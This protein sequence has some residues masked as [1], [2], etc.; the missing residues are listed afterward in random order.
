MV[1]TALQYD[2]AQDVRHV[3][4]YRVEAINEDQDG[5]VYVAIFTG[6]D[7][8][9]RASEYAAWKS[10]GGTVKLRTAN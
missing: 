5:E 3:G 9:L 4:D 1:A 10:A 7:A 8:E 2:V 6:P